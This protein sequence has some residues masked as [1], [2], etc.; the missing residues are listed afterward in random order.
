MARVAV[1]RPLHLLLAIS[2]VAPSGCSALVK[3]K[4]SPSRS[5]HRTPAR[6]FSWTAS[7]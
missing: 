3:E 4:T 1:S 7:R 5:R 6:S 2:L